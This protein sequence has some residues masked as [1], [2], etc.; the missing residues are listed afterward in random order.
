ME[1]AMVVEFVKKALLALALM[2]VLG[3]AVAHP[4]PGGDPQDKRPGCPAHEIC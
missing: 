4:L 3:L 2:T 1:A